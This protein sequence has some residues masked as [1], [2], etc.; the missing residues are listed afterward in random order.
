MECSFC[1][2]FDCEYGPCELCPS[3]ERKFH[4]TKDGLCERCMICKTCKQPNMGW[5]YYDERWTC[6]SC[7]DDWHEYSAKEMTEYPYHTVRKDV[8][9]YLKQ[10]IWTS[11]FG[12]AKEGP[13]F[14]CKV[15]LIPPRF[16]CVQK[17]ND[18]LPI[19]SQ[20][21][22]SMGSLTCEEFIAQLQALLQIHPQKNGNYPLSQES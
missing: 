11:V 5:D 2:T 13:C 17:G 9:R 7:L 14:C 21:S 16:C 3:H 12:S 1:G 4:V 6:F 8:P 20:C 10:S 19:C 15:I 22:K 18:F